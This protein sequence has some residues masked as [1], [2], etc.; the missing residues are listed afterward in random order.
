MQVA[1][2][3]WWRDE[4][5]GFAASALAAPSRPAADESGAADLFTASCEAAIVL[6]RLAALRG[7][8]EYRASVPAAPD[9]EYDRWA[10][11]LLG[12]LEPVYRPLGADAAAYGLALGRWRA[13]GSAGP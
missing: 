1:R 10:G 4:R 3:E 11:R 5:A 9:V 12:G 6:C 8:P 2:R 7:D 13:L